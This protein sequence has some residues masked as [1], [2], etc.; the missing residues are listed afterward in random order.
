[1]FLTFT[2][3][4]FSRSFISGLSRFAPTVDAQ[5]VLT[6]GVTAV[7]KVV[8]TEEVSGVLKAF[9]GAI[10]S[11]FYLAAGVPITAFVFSWGMG[12]QSIKKKKIVA[13]EA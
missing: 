7:R 5:I 4:I 9:S 13:L 11:D 2:Q 10:N 1:M 12:W 3:L 6:A 8:K